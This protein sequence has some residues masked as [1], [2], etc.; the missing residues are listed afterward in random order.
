MRA[1]RAGASRWPCCGAGL[2]IWLL[3]QQHASFPLWETA[4]R[5]R[6]ETAPNSIQVETDSY[7]DLREAG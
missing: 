2:C 7:T 3:T 1:D 4:G 5:G 6:G